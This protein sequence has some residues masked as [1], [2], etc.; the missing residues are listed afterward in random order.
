MKFLKNTRIAIGRSL[1]SNNLKK[2]RRKKQVYNM[3][4]AKSIGFVYVYKNDKEFQIVEN[5]IS[6]LKKELK[7]VKALVYL[8]YTKLATYLPQKISINY[9]SSA[10]LNLIYYPKTKY[11]NDFI[12]TKFDILIDLNLS[13]LFPLEYITTITN[14]S[15]KVGLFDEKKQKVYDMMLKISKEERLDL[16]IEELINYL[17][18]LNPA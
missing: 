10:D 14:A 8:P 15:F 7:N 9:I 13:D 3:D 12:H 16:I 18:M 5:L 6:D 17:K 2:I 11:A 4:T 1:L